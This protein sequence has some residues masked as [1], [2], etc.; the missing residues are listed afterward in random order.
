MKLHYQLRKQN[1]TGKR[2][3]C[4][5]CEQFAYDIPISYPK[6]DKHCKSISK[7]LKKKKNMT[8]TINPK[9]LVIMKNL[10]DI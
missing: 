3:I 4:Q 5:F 2:E 6:K 1:L 9:I 7:P 8:I 10:L